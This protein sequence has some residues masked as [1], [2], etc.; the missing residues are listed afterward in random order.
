MSFKKL[1]ILH[2]RVQFDSFWAIEIL[3]SQIA[4]VDRIEL[5]RFLITLVEYNSRKRGIMSSF[6]HLRSAP[7]HREPTTTVSDLYSSREPFL[8]AI[9]RFVPPVDHKIEHRS[10]E[11]VSLSHPP[12]RIQFT[13]EGKKKVLLLAAPSSFSAFAGFST[14]PPAPVHRWT[15]ETDLCRTSLWKSLTC[16]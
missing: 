8:R 4:Q 14:F 6:L 15:M 10:K 12:F 13:S 2:E 7:V 1:K 5:F 11:N 16:P 3:E 9:I